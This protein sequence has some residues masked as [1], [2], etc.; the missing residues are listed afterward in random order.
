MTFHKRFSFGAVILSIAIAA[1]FFARK[2]PSI[3]DAKKYEVKKKDLAI[4]VSGTSTGAIKA[5]ISMTRRSSSPTSLPAT[6]TARWAGG[7][8]AFLRA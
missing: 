6:L 8:W 4:R 3:M 2:M 7:L 1:L 5:D